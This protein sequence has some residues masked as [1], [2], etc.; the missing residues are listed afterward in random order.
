MKNM[1]IVDYIIT[2]NIKDFQKSII[3][4]KTPEELILIINDELV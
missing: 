1:V 2:S 4:A 3:P